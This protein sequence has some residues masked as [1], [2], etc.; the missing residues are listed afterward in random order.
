MSDYNHVTKMVRGR[1]TKEM[2]I[3]IPPVHGQT[4]SFQVP[5]FTCNNRSIDEQRIKKHPVP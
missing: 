1:L 4:D 5:E 3:E 2:T